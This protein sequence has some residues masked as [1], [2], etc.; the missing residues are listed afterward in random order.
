M[1]SSTGVNQVPRDQKPLG[2][3][4]LWPTSNAAGKHRS[5]LQWLYHVSSCLQHYNA[6]VLFIR[7]FHSLHTERNS[8]GKTRSCCSYM[9]C[10]FWGTQPPAQQ[11]KGWSQA[12]AQPL[13]ST[14]HIALGRGQS[15]EGDSSGISA[16]GR[17]EAGRGRESQKGEMKAQYYPHDEIQ[18]FPGTFS[19]N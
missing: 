19:M 13:R 5:S 6:N 17:A 18:D 14:T 4:F 9:H 1:I 8:A 3:K 10:G 2:G 15:R 11:G 12:P 7:L 16:P